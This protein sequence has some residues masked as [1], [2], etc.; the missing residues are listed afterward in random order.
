MIGL[1]NGTTGP[2]EPPWWSHSRHG[3]AG[4]S[5]PHSKCFKFLDLCAQESTSREK[6][7]IGL[8]WAPGEGRLLITVPTD[9]IQQEEILLQKEIAVLLGSEVDASQPK[10]KQKKQNYPLH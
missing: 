9:W 7:S 1:I 6:A 8:T 10:T 3:M 2:Q 5:P 4:R